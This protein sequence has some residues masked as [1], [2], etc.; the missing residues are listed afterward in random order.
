MTRIGSVPAHTR[1]QAA[2]VDKETNTAYVGFYSTEPH[3][4]MVQAGHG[5]SSPVSVG[6]FELELGA[7]IYSNAAMLLCNYC[8]LL[9]CIS[10]NSPSSVNYYK[11]GDSTSFPK[12]LTAIPVPTNATAMAG[13]IEYV[14][15]SYLKCF[16]SGGGRVLTPFIRTYTASTATYTL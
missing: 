16:M 7:G 11:P 13:A 15:R 6:E 3:V 4:Q 14:G 12:L 5:D 8:N 10:E 2:V 1:V 9:V